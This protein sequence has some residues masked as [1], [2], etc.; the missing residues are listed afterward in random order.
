[1]TTSEKFLSLLKELIKQEI[2]K[3][4]CTEM[5][6]IVSVNSDGSLNINVLPDLNTQFFNIINASKYEF[7][8]GDIGILYKI[9][10]NI[11]NSFVI[12]KYKV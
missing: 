11:G 8:P 4:D 10:N 1:M 7:V 12:A 6:R 2:S 5:C 9:K 3:R